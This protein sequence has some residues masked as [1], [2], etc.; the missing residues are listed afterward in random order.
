MADQLIQTRIVQTLNDFRGAF[1]SLWVEKMNG[2]ID[3][4]IHPAE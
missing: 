2:V 3:Q 1:F 4:V